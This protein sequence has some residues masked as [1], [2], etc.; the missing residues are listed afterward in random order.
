MNYVAERRRP[1]QQAHFA[2]DR[3]TLPWAALGD[4]HNR[5]AIV[6]PWLAMVA[7][8]LFAALPGLAHGPA[9]PVGRIN[10]L[11]DI[12]LVASVQALDFVL[13]RLAAEIL[14]SAVIPL[15]QL[16]V[17]L[18]LVRGTLRCLEFTGAA[19]NIGLLIVP[20]LPLAVAA[21]APM[22]LDSQGW[23]ALCVLAMLR[24]LVDRRAIVMKSAAAGL[25]AGLLTSFSLAGFVV[26]T[27][28]GGLLL[29]LY[30]RDGD[31]RCLAA[32]LGAMAVGA[33][34][35]FLAT[36]PIANWLFA[37]PGWM[38]WPHL[39]GCWSA[40]AIAG[41]L[42]MR[43]SRSAPVSRII[44]AGALVAAAL[45]APLLA[46]GAAILA[47]LVAPG[48]FTGGQGFAAVHSGTGGWHDPIGMVVATFVLWVAS[49]TTRWHQMSRSG[50]PRGWLAVASLA[51]AMVLLS[52]LSY[53]AALFAQLLAI[54][55]FALL[56]RDALRVASRM[57]NA[58]LR[59]TGIALAL[60]VLT[61]TGGSVVGGIA[62]SVV[63]GRAIT[64]PAPVRY[65]AT[66]I[67]AVVARA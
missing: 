15:M 51:G 67:A 7:V 16:L 64:W 31:A 29:L 32:Y 5:S 60:F 56:L 8:L 59:V 53:R 48:P 22:R 19:A 37:S 45:A 42:A 24:L 23:E 20:L 66:S 35:L 36:Q 33:S 41:V 50:N 44:G 25:V 39:A 54:P 40:A 18:V 57:G 9:A 26:A 61:P 46:F 6:L 10:T 13:P 49:V 58:P 21:F 43:N 52:L 28:A 4:A 12:P 2:T 34:G 65:A 3:L 30:L 14:A 38:S 27:A 47:P 11:S 17:A 55:L 63:D 1:I 62:F